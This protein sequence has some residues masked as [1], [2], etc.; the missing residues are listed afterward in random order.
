[1]YQPLQDPRERER[2]L[3]GVT[4]YFEKLIPIHGRPLRRAT[5]KL[6]VTRVISRAPADRRRQGRNLWDF[7]HQ[8]VTAWIDKTP[9]P[10]MMPPTAA[11]TPTG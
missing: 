9:A 8:A 2:E 11:V 3:I 4:R 7:M 1:M 6:K 5:L 10:S